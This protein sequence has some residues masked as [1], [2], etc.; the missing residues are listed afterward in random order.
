MHDSVSSLITIQKELKQK[1]IDNVKWIK[2]PEIIAV[3]KTFKM[4]NILPLINHGHLH[5]GENKVQEAMQKWKSIK[6]D[7]KYLNLHM[8]GKLQTN[9]VKQAI[10]LFDYIH[11]LDN[12]RLAR[13][14][15]EE[16][17][18]QNKKPKIFIQVNIA[19]EENKSGIAI[20][21]INSFYEQC[22]SLNLDIIGTMCI[23]PKIK[24]SKNYF[25]EMYK[26]NTQ[27]KLPDLSMG[28][29]ED[30]MEAAENNSTFLRIGS[31]IFGDRD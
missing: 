9:K 10:S 31:K 29:S 12:L 5:F 26:I 15:S 7:F 27:L 19:N 13:K 30:Y 3:S 18:K 21:N 11:S 22:L 2:T 23:P 20:E 28:M 24:D 8:I 16:Q 25:L 6:L 1:I 17:I 14:I 4:V